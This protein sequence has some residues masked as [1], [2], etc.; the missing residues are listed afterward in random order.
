MTP[1]QPDQYIIIINEE[2]IDDFMEAINIGIDYTGLDNVKHD[3][4][5]DNYGTCCNH[6]IFSRGN[7]AVCNVCGKIVRLT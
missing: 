1:K 3:I 6:T 2:N 7:T 4:E 5:F